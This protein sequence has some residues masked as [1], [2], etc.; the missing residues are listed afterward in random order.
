MKKNFVQY[1]GSKLITASL[2]TGRE[3]KNKTS[4]DVFKVL[5]I[6]INN[7]NFMYQ[8]RFF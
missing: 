7:Y 8:L 3:L 1:Q 4:R 5:E 2:N 6:P